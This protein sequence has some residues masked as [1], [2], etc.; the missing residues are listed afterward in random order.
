MCSGCPCG[1]VDTQLISFSEHLAFLMPFDEPWESCCMVDKQ[2]PREQHT[3]AV[4]AV[5]YAEDASAAALLI[6]ALGGCNGALDL[7]MTLELFAGFS[8][9][10]HNCTLLLLF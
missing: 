7:S 10:L 5:A 4:P 2:E 6:F 9:F 3:L 8:V 1:D